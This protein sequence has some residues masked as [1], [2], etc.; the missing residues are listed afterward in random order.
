MLFNLLIV[1]SQKKP[2]NLGFFNIHTCDNLKFCCFRDQELKMKSVR[3]HKATMCTC[4]FGR[5]KDLLLIA[6]V[7][8]DSN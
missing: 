6:F 2:Y 5:V 4:I 8:A 1:M 7:F 3:V